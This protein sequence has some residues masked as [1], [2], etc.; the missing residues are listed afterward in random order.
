MRMLDK[1]MNYDEAVKYC[2]DNGYRLA[3]AKEIVDLATHRKVLYWIDPEKPDLFTYRRVVYP[4]TGEVKIA[5]E[6]SSCLVMVFR[7]PWYK[8][9]FKSI[10]S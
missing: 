4:N 8:R 6:Y 2:T 5:A 1:Y 7:L 9:L 10:I 3:T